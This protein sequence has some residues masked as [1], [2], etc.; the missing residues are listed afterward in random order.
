MKIKLE[1]LTDVLFVIFIF[2]SIVMQASKIG[3]IIQLISSIMLLIIVLSQKPKLYFY[4][5]LEIIFVA[6]V[7]MQV[8]FNIAVIKNGTLNTANTILYNFSFSFSIFNYCIY[9]KDLKKVIKIYARTTI[10]GL[11][12]LL[13]FNFRSMISFRFNASTIISIMGIKL[14]GGQ[15]S[16]AL[17][18]IAAIPAFFLSIFSNTEERKENIV[19]TIILLAFA[20]MTGTRKT[21]IIFIFILFVVYPLKNKKIT[22]SRIL[23]ICISI[24]IMMGLTFLILTK[25]PF[26][27]NVIGNRVEA[28]IAIFFKDED[29]SIDASIKVRD[30][31]IR[32]SQ[33]LFEEKPTLGWG[34]DYFRL[35]NQS[36]L[37]YYSHNNYMEMLVGGGI[38]GAIL[39]YSKYIWL[40]A[41]SYRYAIKN[42]TDSKWICILMFL[43]IMMLIEYWQVT[44][45]YRYIIIYQPIILAMILT[46][47][48]KNKNI[49]QIFTKS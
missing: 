25:I 34:M 48:D 19:Y 35:S 16:T 14:I 22:I 31:M 28:A 45:I 11:T 36:G 39:Y 3:K 46:E 33:E 47:K 43:L 32:R 44:Y 10:I 12:F 2:S 4:H 15:S 8:L 30:R 21:L 7:Y 1:K 17:A 5:I 20:L 29:K 6:F 24:S 18:L 41:I 26:I 37:G 27:Y 38:T 49:Q 40:L 13:F 9:K 23:K 42:K